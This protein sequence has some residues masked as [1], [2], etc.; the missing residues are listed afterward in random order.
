MLLQFAKKLE[1]AVSC[2]TNSE[3]LKAVQKHLNTAL[4]L[5]NATCI[6]NAA[7]KANKRV[8]P[9]S[10]IMVRISYVF[11]LLGKIAHAVRD[12]QNQLTWN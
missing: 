5:I 6:D 11:N 3:I 8:A 2:S 10:N 12:F 7:F 9:N 4:T 1:V